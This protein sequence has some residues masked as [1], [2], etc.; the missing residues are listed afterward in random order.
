MS[1]PEPPIAPSTGEI[2][3]TRYL[4]RLPASLD[5]LT[6]PA[7]GTVELPLH[8]AWSGLTAF[9]VEQPKPRMSMYR[10]VL[11][12]GQRADLSAYLNRDLLI[13]QWPVQRMGIR[14]P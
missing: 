8:V 9:D 13:T 5:E 12:E 6:G 14:V 7:C 1:A 10:I 2:L 4:N 3:L 11:A